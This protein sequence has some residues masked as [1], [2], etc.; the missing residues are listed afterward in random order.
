[1]QEV[2][3]DGGLGAVAAA[4]RA[5]ASGHLADAHAML[6]RH[7]AASPDDLPAM[8]LLSQTCFRM[9]MRDAGFEAA[10]RAVDLAPG[11]IA[12]G[13]DAAFNLVRA[14]RRGDALALARRI[15]AQAPSDP[16]H[17]DT[18]GTIFTHCEAP[19]EAIDHFAAACAAA[20]DEPGL[21]FNLAS[22]QRMVGLKKKA[23]DSL[24]R[25]IAI[26]PSDGTAW[27]A[28]SSIRR[29]TPENHHVAQL[30]AALRA[31]GETP[32]A[33]PIGYAL[34]KELEDLGRY[35][36]SFAALD[37]ASRRQR[38]SME[39]DEAGEI[40]LMAA[41][42]STACP[43]L[44]ATE[45][46]PSPPIF[47]FGLP[48]SGTTLV[49]RIVT[50][51]P[52]VHSA[53]E[54]NGL[55]AEVWR[56]AS[57]DGRPAKSV[58]AVRQAIETEAAAI[59]RNYMAAV[60]QKF[61]EGV[62]VDKTPSHYLFAGLIRAA[63]PGARIICLRRDP[64]DSCYAMY[65]TLFKGIYPFTYDLGELATYYAHWHALI[66]HWETTMGDAWLTVDYEDLVR[67]P[68][69]A[70]RRIVTHAGLPWGPEYARFHERTAPVTSASA[71]QVDRP[72]YADSIGQWRRY[73]DELRPLRDRLRALGI[74]VD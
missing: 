32:A 46:A 8:R 73:A 28:R 39:Y 49:E 57:R 53:G 25:M 52:G 65:K 4:S 2:R 61:P 37:M 17:H 10:L 9:G 19:E 22:A 54:T 48:R 71:G 11:D 45:T 43:P 50:S 27:L 23:E 59:G 26:D 20:P 15:A 67:H 51:H 62:F 74:V 24:D 29:Q 6:S 64:M 41:M 47:I 63:I 31:A 42:R 60:R 34:A 68:E 13:L 55:A 21:L 66:A 3:A 12:Y 30:E 33:I 70:M 44:P 40:A 5:I 16:Y 72:I 36:E 58:A 1:M 38:A 7:V 18:L 56:V 35:A 69:P 14:G